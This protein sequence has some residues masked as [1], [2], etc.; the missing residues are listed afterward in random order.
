MH[1]DIHASIGIR[2]H[3]P[4]VRGGEDSSC[5]ET[6][7]PLWSAFKI[8]SCYIFWHKESK[9]IPGQVR[10]LMHDCYE[11]NAVIRFLQRHFS[12]SE[13]FVLT[14]RKTEML[15]VS[16]TVYFALAVWVYEWQQTGFG[17]VIGFIV[18][19]QII[20][21]SNYSAVANS[22]TLQFS[23]ARTNCSQFAVFSPV[24]AW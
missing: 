4:S 9:D 13:L 24:F 8:S 20:T 22:H 7:R 14:L 11:S 3:D 23:T 19:L 5:L 10:M 1:I 18:H 2:T 6:A 17:W 21:T 15:D 16:G 12:R